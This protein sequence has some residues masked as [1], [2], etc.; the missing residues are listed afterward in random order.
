MLFKLKMFEDCKSSCGMNNKIKLL[1]F[2]F[3][4]ANYSYCQ[5]IFNESFDICCI[6]SLKIRKGNKV[7]YYIDSNFVVDYSVDI[8][9][10]DKIDEYIK[11]N[12]LLS[13]LV[14]FEILKND[15]SKKRKYLAYL[16]LFESTKK[17]YIEFNEH[18][19]YK[20]WDVLSINK[21]V[22]FWSELID[23]ITK[24]FPEECRKLG[25]H[26]ISQAPSRNN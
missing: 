1:F 9:G 20:I 10:C 26:D 18:H 21:E 22:I 11:Y 5:S 25:Y 23:R 15:K 4:I 2:I 19:R 7:T 17:R 24:K 14:F 3:T 8:S 16:Y 12:N 6:D 13:T